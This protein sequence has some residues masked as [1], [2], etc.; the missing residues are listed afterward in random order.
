VEIDHR[1]LHGMQLAALAAQVLDGDDMA[2]VDR[3]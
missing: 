2:S 3:A 1:L